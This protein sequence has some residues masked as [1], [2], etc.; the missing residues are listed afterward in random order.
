MNGLAENRKIYFTLPSHVVAVHI[1]IRTLGIVDILLIHH[2]YAHPL[3]FHTVILYVIRAPNPAGNS[4]HFF[5]FL[6]HIK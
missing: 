4:V 3:K 6:L 1:T 2:I 5:L